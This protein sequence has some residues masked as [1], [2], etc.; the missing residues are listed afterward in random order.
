LA[1]GGEG[2]QQLKQARNETGPQQRQNIHINVRDNFLLNFLLEVLDGGESDD[3]AL[4]S[5]R[6]TVAVLPNGGGNE[7]VDRDGM[8]R[9]PERAPREHW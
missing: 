6:V 1:T 7:Q 8:H 9:L 5:W 3:E 4:P 2:G